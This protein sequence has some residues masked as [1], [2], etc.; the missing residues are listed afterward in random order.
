MN[1]PCILKIASARGQGQRPPYVCPSVAAEEEEEAR[2]QEATHL[3]AAPREQ[4][5]P[6]HKG[7]SPLVS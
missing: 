3:E 4:L 2:L 7:S 1:K 5:C 6:L